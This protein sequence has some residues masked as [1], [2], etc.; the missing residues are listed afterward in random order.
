M[1]KSF[2]TKG[3]DICKIVF[4][5]DTLIS[6]LMDRDCIEMLQHIGALHYIHCCSI[7]D[8]PSFK[9]LKDFY[10]FV[11]LVGKCVLPAL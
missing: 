11:I 4:F 5:W 8:Y 1:V 7:C 6:E 2:K 10:N 9:T 3:W